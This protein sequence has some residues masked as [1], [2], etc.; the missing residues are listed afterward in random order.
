MA[1]FIARA[2][3]RAETSATRLGSPASGIQADCNGWNVGV[4]VYGKAVTG[5]FDSD[6][7]EI[8]A[9]GG[10]NNHHSRKLIATVVETSDGFE[11]IR[12]N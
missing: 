8:Y 10:S 2:T 12:P 1:R 9:T 6:C 11:V 4:T 7:F 3:G 5:S